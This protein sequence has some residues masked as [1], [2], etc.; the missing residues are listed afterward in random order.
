MDVR[1]D[2]RYL[3][4][5]IAA[6]AALPVGVFVIG[7]PF[8][9]AVP[10]A[11]VLFA[12]VALFLAPRRPLE[13]VDV[14][15]LGRGDVTAARAALEDADQD[16]DAIEDAAKRIHTADIA[17][18]VTH[19]A[20]TARGLLTQV[21]AEPAKLSEIRRLV[22]VYLPR[23]RDITESYADIESR[24]KLDAARTERVRG[25]LKR[26]DDTFQHFGQRLVEG[27]AKSL[28]VDLT[29]LEDSIKQELESRP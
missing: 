2:G 26:I 21:E 10:I 20:T 14:K 29:L 19:L 27:E 12:G 13:G 24:G 15:A 5:G 17:Q 4:A 8:Y 11:A 1:G 23:T 22:A 25:V 7:I 9:V 16:L 28:D 3:V 6:A 18:A